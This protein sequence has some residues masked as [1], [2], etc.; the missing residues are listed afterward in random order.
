MDILGIG[1]SIAG[2]MVVDKAVDIFK[3]K[4]KNRIDPETIVDLAFAVGEFKARTKNKV[5]TPEEIAEKKRLKEEKRAKEKK[6]EQERLARNIKADYFWKN[7]IL[8][9]YDKYT[10]R[11]RMRDEAEPLKMKK[12]IK[13]TEDFVDGEPGF[14]IL[15]DN[16]KEYFSWSYFF[17]EN[18]P[19][20]LEFLPARLKHGQEMKKFLSEPLWVKIK[21]KLGYE[22]KP[23][24]EK[25]KNI[26]YM[27]AGCD[28]LNSFD[29]HLPNVERG[30]YAFF[31][32]NIKKF[33][34]NVDKIK[35]TRGMFQNSSIE[36]FSSDMS[37]I[38]FEKSDTRGM[39]ATTPIKKLL[40]DYRCVYYYL[41]L[42]DYIKEALLL[43][44]AV[45]MTMKISIT[46]PRAQSFI[47][48]D[49]DVAEE[50]G[51]EKYK[52]KN[53][54][55]FTQEEKDDIDRRLSELFSV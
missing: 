11:T 54:T 6:E 20:T 22:T 47:T 39:F 40:G 53:M 42:D 2:G 34:V 17:L 46:Y 10:N 3:G 50:R 26:S 55:E 19:D 7:E 14:I 1:A 27:F 15:M 49:D 36:V 31:G 48:L 13:Y 43:E 24:L 8:D 38:S 52:F 9:K 45:Y 28:R 16:G 5:L 44:I 33:D 29:F 21:R 25:I 18:N 35:Y 12:L 37:N 23:D 51:Q 30:N 32:T 41:F 4:D